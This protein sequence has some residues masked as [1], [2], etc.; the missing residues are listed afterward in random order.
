MY[1]IVDYDAL[2]K[3]IDEE[4]SRVADKAFGD[5]GLPLYDLIHITS[6]DHDALRRYIDDAVGK[7]VSRE[8]DICKYSPLIEI[9]EHDNEISHVRLD[10]NVPDIEEDNIP[11]AERELARYLV[12]YATA[13][14]LGP[15]KADRAQEYVTLQQAAMDK[16]VQYLKTRKNPVEDL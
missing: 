2:I 8:R 11:L 12:F 4:I 7:F 3:S 6:S 1:Y 16:A 10:I 13:S 5:Q 15:L 9:D 14:H